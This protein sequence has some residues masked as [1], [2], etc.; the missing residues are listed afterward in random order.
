MLCYNSHEYISVMYVYVCVVQERIFSIKSVNNSARTRI[1]SQS[2][3]Q[4]DEVLERYQNSPIFHGARIALKYCSHRSLREL[5]ACITSSHTAIHK[6]NWLYRNIVKSTLTDVPH[7][8]GWQRGFVVS[9]AQASTSYMKEAY[10][11]I[12]V[13]LPYFSRMHLPSSCASMKFVRF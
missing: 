4:S 6:A 12:F 1:R 5:V 10:V 8:L 13:C 11:E 2:D 3:G 9:A 7:I